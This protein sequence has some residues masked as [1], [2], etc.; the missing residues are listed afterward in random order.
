MNTENKRGMQNKTIKKLIRK[1]INHWIESITDDKLQKRVQNNVIVTG[2]SIAS[3]AMGDTVNDYDV[4]FRD[5][6]TTRKVAEYYAKQVNESQFR[7]N[8]D[9]VEVREEEKTNIK[10]E[11]E[12]R[13]TL[14]IP[15]CG[16]A[17]ETETEEYEMNDDGVEDVAEEEDKGYKVQWLS[18]NAITLTNK[19]QIVIRFYGDPEQIHKNFDFKHAMCWYDYRNDDLNIPLESARS[20]MSKTLYY[21]GSLYPICSLFRMR[22]FINRGWNI[23][24]GEIMKIAFQ[25]SEINLKD[26]DAL[27][28]QLTGVDQ[29][30]FDQLY[31]ALESVDSDK[32]T[33]SYVGS[34]IDKI[35]GDSDC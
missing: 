30:Y 10:G 26:K 3:M 14:Y 1:K 28:E 17:S 35:F 25:I 16:Y 11:T 13:V 32:I 24:A 8:D 6:K 33:S 12:S 4:Y 22:K 18:E 34:I 2:G 27:R 20:M 9:A 5:K 15:S 23:S 29:L 19:L 31:Y 21:S 7:T